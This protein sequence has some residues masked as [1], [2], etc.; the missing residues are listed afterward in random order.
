ML[1]YLY[2]IPYEPDVFNGGRPSE[3]TDSVLTHISNFVV[4]DKYDA[5]TLRKVAA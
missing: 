1:R 4:A 2:N 3:N 5:P